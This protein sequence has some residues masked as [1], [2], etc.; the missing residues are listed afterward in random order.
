LVAGGFPQCFWA[1]ATGAETAEAGA[2]VLVVVASAEV[3]EVLVVLEAEAVVVAVQVAVGK[4]AINLI[5]KGIENL[6]DKNIFGIC[7]V[8][9]R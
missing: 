4:W 5:F 3:A 2:V 7:R 8:G 1:V 9:T 6:P